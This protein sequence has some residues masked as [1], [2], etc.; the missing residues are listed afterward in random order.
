MKAAVVCANEDVHVQMKMCV[1]W[2]MKNRCQ[3]RE[4][5]KSE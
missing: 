1:I 3:V 5:L 2:I 4:R